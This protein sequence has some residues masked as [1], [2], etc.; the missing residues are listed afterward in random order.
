M[1]FHPSSHEHVQYTISSKNP[2][3]DNFQVANLNLQKFA[4]D[5]MQQCF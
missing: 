3:L 4:D 2:P 5:E 1:D